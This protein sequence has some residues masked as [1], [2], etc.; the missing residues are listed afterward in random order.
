MLPV[1]MNTQALHNYEVT[2]ALTL[3]LNNRHD[4]QQDIRARPDTDDVITRSKRT[5]L[6]YRG[7][8]S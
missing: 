6:R 3:N 7:G 4:V 2:T 5:R 1:W 8:S